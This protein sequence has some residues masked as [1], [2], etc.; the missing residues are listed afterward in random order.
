M[1]SILSI[2]L[3]LS[4]HYCCCAVVVS[5]VLK[6]VEMATVLEVLLTTHLM[7][8]LWIFCTAARKSS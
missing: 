5:D 7:I 3:C 8:N 1:V 4:Y 2:L 6:I